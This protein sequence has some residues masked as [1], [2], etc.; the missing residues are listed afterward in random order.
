M[1]LTG[2]SRP[3]ASEGEKG[4]WAGRR[5]SGPEAGMGWRPKE[6]GKGLQQVERAEFEGG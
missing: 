2:G 1:T 5:D 3:S 4:S 6:N